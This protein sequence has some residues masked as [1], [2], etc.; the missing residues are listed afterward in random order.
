MFLSLKYLYASSVF[1]SIHRKVFMTS[2]ITFNDTYGN[3][4]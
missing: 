2:E 3:K 1:D 4:L